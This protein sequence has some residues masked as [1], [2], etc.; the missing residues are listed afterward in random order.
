MKEQDREN[1][2]RLFREHCNNLGV[3]RTTVVALNAFIDAI[4]ALRCTREDVLDLYGELARAIKRTEPAIVPLIHLIEQFEAEMT[5][6][7]DGDLDEIRSQAVRLLKEKIFQFENNRYQVTMHGIQHVEDGDGIIV[8]SPSAVV[9]D[10]L[11][12]AKTEQGRDF[13][14]IVL[15]QNRVRTRQLIN[16]LTRAGIAHEVIPEYNLCHHLTGANKQFIGAVTVTPDRKIIAPPGTA[17]AVHLAYAHN[18][19][20]YLFANTLHYSHHPVARQRIHR[21]DEARNDNGT[22]YQM[23]VHSHD[24]IDLSLIGHIINEYGETQ[25]EAVADYHR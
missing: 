21:V 10:I 9:T 19:V 16:A 4:Q 5:A 2:Y 22:C 24:I 13:Q 20:V 18:I 7:P 8:H 25:V 12:K 17:N 23:T 3:A 6:N 1:L 11:V 14:V 15:Q